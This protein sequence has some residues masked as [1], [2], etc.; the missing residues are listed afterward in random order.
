MTY[1]TSVRKPRRVKAAF[2]GPIALALTLVMC[3]FAV[4]IYLVEASVRDRDLAERSAAAA[5]LFEQKLGK[6]A[7][8]MRAVVRAMT[9]NRTLEKAFRDRDRA[10]L[11][12]QT[13][14][15]FETLRAEHRITHL[16]F[17]GD[18]LIN[19][20]RVHSPDEFGDEI[21]RITMH[22]ARDQAAA[23]SGLELGPLGTLTLRM[24]VPWRHNGKV[25][26][27]LEIGEEV[28]HLIDEIRDSLTVDL[29]VLV[30]KKFLRPEQWQRGLGMMQ[31]KGDWER[32]TTHVALAQT[33]E[34]L[35]TAFDGQMLGGLLAGRNAVIEDGGRALHLAPVPLTDAGGRHIGEL[36][37]IRDIAA[38]QATFR[39]SIATVTLLSLLVAAGVL[40]IFYVALDRVERDY[41]RQHDLEL[42][43][44]RLNTD[45]TR[46]LQLEKLSALGTMVGGIAHQLNNPLVGVVNMAQ[47]AERETG[48]PQPTRELLGEI[49]RAGEDCRAFVR[50]MLEF[51]KVSCFDSKSTPMGALIEDTVL[52]FRQAEDRHHPVDIRLPPEPVVL[53][54]DPILIRHA[55]FNLLLNAAQAAGGDDPIIISLEPGTDPEGDAAGWWLAVT[56]CG[57]VIPPEVLEKVFVPFFTTR[58][59]GTGLGLPVVQHVALLHGGHVSAASAPASGTRFALWLP[60]IQPRSA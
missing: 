22:K 19:L 1:V 59:D 51:S 9:T 6:D 26:G 28:E 47:L 5:K 60:I 49:R 35:P 10:S 31:R 18:D 57:K 14:P 13:G 25:F 7:N 41:Q 39:R 23:V 36:V 45:H 27:Y 20:Y 42:Q 21:D 15:L 11:A 30:D 56:D 50:R 40:G 37:V 24:V 33:S 48:N 29:A 58:S 38:L 34:Q 53:T 43:I 8:L 12:R 4:A 52:M 16:Y 17:T 2:I 44:L 54:V 32:F 46:I 3:V 55:L